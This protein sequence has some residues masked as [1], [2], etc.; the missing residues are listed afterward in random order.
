MTLMPS[1]GVSFLSD[2]I[3][4]PILASTAVLIAI[5]AFRKGYFF[6]RDKRVIA[7]ATLGAGL[8]LFSAFNLNHVLSEIGERNATLL[9]GLLI[10]TGHV[11]NWRL[12]RLSQ[13]C[14]H[15]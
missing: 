2:E 1:L 14:P 8:L 7:V 15:E 4:H 13:C 5:Q 9:G 11:W 10:S 6:H 3:F 12:I